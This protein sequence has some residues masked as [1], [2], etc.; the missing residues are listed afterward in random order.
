MVNNLE[1]LYMEKLGMF[2][3]TPEKEKEK[4]KSGHAQYFIIMNN[5]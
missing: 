4:E 5:Y 2:H 3:P 1:K